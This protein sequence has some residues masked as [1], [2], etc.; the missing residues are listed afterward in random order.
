MSDPRAAKREPP[1]LPARSRRYIRRSRPLVVGAL[2]VAHRRANVVGPVRLACEGDTLRIELLEVG[3]LLPGF[4]HAG[5]SRAITFRVPYT[6]VRGLVRDGATLQLALDA[7]VAAPHSRFVLTRFSRDTPWALARA[8]HLRRFVAALCWA[9][10]LPAAALT[11]GALPAELVAGKLGA[12]AVALVAAFVTYKLLARVLAWVSWGGP[13]SDRLRAAFEH[14]VAARLGLEPAAEM[15]EDPAVLLAPRPEDVPEPTIGAVLGTV[16]RPVAFA[17]AAAL[18]LGGGVL[19]VTLVQTY[20][21]T[22]VVVLPVDDAVSGAGAPVLRVAAAAAKLAT[23]ERPA[24]S[25]QRTNTALFGNGAPQLTI[26]AAPIKGGLATLW[27][28]PGQTYA[29]AHSD[30]DL[31]VEL[32]VAVVNNGAVALAGVDLVLTFARRDAAGKRRH[33]IE[34]GLSWPS[35]LGPG[36]SVKWRVTASGTELK[37]D[38]HFDARLGDGGLLPAGTDAF[39][40]LGRARLPVVRLHGAMMLAYL[41]DER[42]LPMAKGVDGLAV[43]AEHAKRGMLDA[44]EPLHL[45]DVAATGAGVKACLHN[46]TDSLHRAMVVSELGADPARSWTI[47]DLFGPRRGLVVHIPTGESRPNAYRVDPQQD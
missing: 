25:C 34:R 2:A 10:P 33:L 21:V 32:D 23:P 16:L 42:A 43:S 20:G 5:P 19:A 4:A 28:E 17:F 13:E 3:R 45:C 8:F 6:S 31:D 9:L 27:L 38:S 7:M 30:G 36:E 24:C 22:S 35:E 46:G 1:P 37:I 11:L 29:V 40:R 18:A 15:S 47:V 12:L 41:G 26:L 14:T 39:V 44:F